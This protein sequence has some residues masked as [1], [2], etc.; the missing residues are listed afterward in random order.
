MDSNNMMVIL[1]VIS[2]LVAIIN[3]VFTCCFWKAE[4]KEASKRFKETHRPRIEVQ[5]IFERK[6]Y[7]GLRFKNNG[8]YLAEEVSVKFDQNFK[9]SLSEQY[10]RSLIKEENNKCRIGPGDYYDIFFA[11]I[12]EKIKINTAKGKIFYKNQNEVYQTDFSINIANYMTIY[13][14]DTEMDLIISEF[15]NLNKSII[16]I[17]NEI[18]LIGVGKSNDEK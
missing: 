4:L 6:L 12:N 1:T 18:D 17:K 14:V 10:K 8:T 3:I 11:K 9:D 16:D 13:S 5:I 2:V 15:R 7:F